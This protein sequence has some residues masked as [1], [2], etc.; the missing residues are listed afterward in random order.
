MMFRFIRRHLFSIVPIAPFLLF[1]LR[2]L[3]PSDP[4][5]QVYQ[6]VSTDDPSYRLTIA[7]V[8]EATV[9]VLRDGKGRTEVSWTDD[10]GVIVGAPKDGPYS[11]PSPESLCSQTQS[12]QSMAK[13]MDEIQADNGD[14]ISAR[15]AMEADYEYFKSAGKMNAD[16]ALAYTAAMMSVVRDLFEKE[17]NVSLQINWFK[18][19]TDE[20]SDPYKVKGNAYAL[21]DPVRAYWSANYK[22]VERDLVH[23]MTSVSYGGGGFGYYDA[24]C[25]KD[26]GFSVSSPTGLQSL[27]TFGFT[28]DAYIVAHELG[29]NFNA[30]HS[31][32]CFWD[33][34]LDTCYTKDDA[35]LSLGDACY[36]R[37]IT[38]RPNN[39]SIMSYCANANYTLSGND[40]S[41]F[42]VDMTF[43]SKVSNYI[44][45]SAVDAVSKGCLVQPNSP[46]L[47]LRTP[48]GEGTVSGGSPLS[49][50][51]GSARLDSVDL[52]YSVDGK[53]WIRI[54]SAIPARPA[55]H[56]WIVP[57][58]ST[59]ALILRIASS[60]DS[61]VK[62]GMVLPLT[63]KKTV[64]VSDNEG[65]ADG[66]TL[67]QESISV[68]GDE[69]VILIVRDLQGRMLAQRD[70]RANTTTSW[71][72]GLLTHGAVFVT[73]SSFEG[74]LLSRGVFLGK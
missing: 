47:Y 53:L 5:V 35:T 19:W 74:R 38:P 21:P 31:H 17:A 46:L 26:Y 30:R 61:A 10:Q 62:D 49:I 33:P 28:Y 2:P 14:A 52:D 55:L 68:N 34:A 8:R 72:E 15:I 48:I 43:L 12:G 22:S 16:R 51:W 37:P 7:T 42:K 73:V 6:G 56:E 3:M 18:V 44:R 39:G 60:R 59:T 9:W 57:N 71:R 50:A 70:L 69:P 11:M 1:P 66:V 41:K 20:A 65:R 63:I 54:A 13:R 40:F 64:G 36:S 29:H 25:N 4:A 23:V 27:P 58:V 67:T 32:D 45:A 24:L